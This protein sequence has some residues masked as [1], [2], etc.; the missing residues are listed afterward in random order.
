MVTRISLVKLKSGVPRDRAVAL[1]L[2][3]HA[4][5]V[6]RCRLVK[7]YEINIAAEERPDDRWDAV[8]ILEFASR[9]DFLRWSNDSELQQDLVRTR[10]PFAQ[11]TEAFLVDAHA[12]GLLWPSED[13]GA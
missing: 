7:R 11:R 4:D 12:V 1:W 5:V 13:S 10:E 2:G 8:A 3:P 9:Q 6:R